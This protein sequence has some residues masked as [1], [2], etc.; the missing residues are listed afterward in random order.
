M[1]DAALGT[2]THSLKTTIP[3]RQ[4]TQDNNPPQ[5]RD[6]SPP[7]SQ[8]DNAEVVYG[9]QARDIRFLEGMLEDPGQPSRDILNIESHYLAC[10]GLKLSATLLPQHLT[11]W[12][13]T[14]MHR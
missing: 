9:H 10:S 5:H 1:C 12:G 3:S 7:T 11:G 4:Q 2:L 6:G 8:A 13:I 14:G